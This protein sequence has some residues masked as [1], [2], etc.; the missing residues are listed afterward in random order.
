[1][2]P[3]VDHLMAAFNVQIPAVSVALIAPRTTNA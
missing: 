3:A 2:N 1:V